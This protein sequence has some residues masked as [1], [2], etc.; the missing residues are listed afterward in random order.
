M[1]IFVVSC[2]DCV[3][4]DIVEEL[5]DILGPFSRKVHVPQW[6]P[7]QRCWV[8]KYGNSQLQVNPHT[9]GFGVLQHPLHKYFNKSHSEMFHR[10]WEQAKG[11]TLLREWKNPI[12]YAFSKRSGRQEGALSGVRRGCQYRVIRVG[13]FSALQ[14]AV[15]LL[16]P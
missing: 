14:L 16:P 6:A 5:L 10:S 4:K 12:A 15:T 13:S 3:V 7:G 8:A 2:D 1:S 9:T 11:K